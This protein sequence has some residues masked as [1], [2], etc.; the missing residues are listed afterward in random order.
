ML[1]TCC[2]AQPSPNTDLGSMLACPP[3]QYYL[4]PGQSNKTILIHYLIMGEV[5]NLV[6]YRDLGR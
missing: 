4:M 6:C 3:I 1:D 2:L 5:P